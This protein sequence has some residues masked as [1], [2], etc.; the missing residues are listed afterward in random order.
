M[1][2]ISMPLVEHLIIFSGLVITT[3]HVSLH[4]GLFIFQ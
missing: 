2:K 3:E 4:L 1:I